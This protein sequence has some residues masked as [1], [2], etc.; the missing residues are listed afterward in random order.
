MT[1]RIVVASLSL[2]IISCKPKEEKLFSVRKGPELGISFKNAIETSDTLNALSFEYIYNGS[3][4]GVGDF[5]KDGLEDLVFGGNQVS[6]RLYL[7]KGNLQFVDVTDSA[8]LV[9][10]QWITGVSI[11]DINQDGLDD[12][13]FCVAGKT[14][15]ENRKNLL[16][17]NKGINN[18]LPHFEEVASQYGLD[19]DSYS[20]MAAFFDYDKDGDLDMY[21]VNNWMEKFNRNNIR[22]IRVNGGAESTDNIYRNNGD[23]TYSDVSREAGVLIEGYGLGIVINDIN[24]D[25][26]PDIYVSNDFLSSDLLWINQ[27]DGTFKNEINRY[28]K[29]TTHNG[30]GMD[31]ADFN[32]D[33]LDDIVVVDM[34]PPGHKRQKLMTA[35]QNFDH[36]NLAV[37]HGYQ[38]QYMRNTLQLNRGKTSSG[39]ILFSEIG[40]M[41]GIAQTDWS[42]APLFADVDNDGLKDLFIGNGYRKDVTD[43]D[44]IFFGGNEG[45][46]FGTTET[47]KATFNKE[48]DELPPVKISNYLFK[49]NGSLQ[50]EDKTKEWGFEM[51]TF[52]NG[53]AYADLDNDGDLDFVTN[54]IDQEVII[55]QNLLQ[56][57][58]SKKNFISIKS[59]DDQ[60]TFNEKIKVFH[61]GQVQTVE[62]TPYRGF[63][64]T[65]T[66][67]VHFG[68][69]VSSSV[70]SVEVW[71]PD[72][73]VS[74]YRNVPANTQLSFSRNDAVLKNISSKKSGGI[75]FLKQPGFYK[76]KETSP[77]DI[78]TTRTLL[79]ELSHYGPCI[80]AGDVNNDALDDLF[81][82]GEA[83]VKSKLFIQQSDGLFKEQYFPS[84]SLREDGDAHFFDWDDDGDLDLYVGGASSSG[85]MLSSPHVLYQND[86]LGRFKPLSSALPALTTS[87]SCVVSA[88]YDDDGDLDLFVGGRFEAGEYPLPARSYILRNDGVKFS[89]ATKNIN[90]LLE[91]PGIVTSAIWAD[92]DQDNQT[93][94]VVAGEWM[95]V[96]VFKNAGNNFKEVTKEFGLD[97]T[98][99]W[100]N[101]VE[102]ADL[103]KDGYPE[104]IA[105][106][107]GINS[108]FKPTLQHPVKITAK[109][110]DNNGSI[111]PIITYYNPFEKKR[112]M[113][114][115]RLVLI[116]QIPA[117]KKRFETFTQYATTPFEEAF[118]QTELEGAYEGS[119]YTLASC[120]FVNREGTK[121]ESQQLP[122]V[123][124]LS[125]VND[126]LIEDLNSD[127][128]DDLILIGNNYS[129]ETLFGMYDASIGCILLGDGN[130]HWRSLSSSETGFVSNKDAKMIKLLQSGSGRKVIIS[131]NNDE[132][133]VF[134]LK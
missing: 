118:T 61:D 46:P 21:L 54:N 128:F 38:P 105:G 59:G 8:G 45:S 130:L 11:V 64:S 52:S 71:W 1:I 123:V 113:V 13:Y 18:G 93:D 9:T 51:D 70:D 48:M 129:Q 2:L 78:K 30:M 116:D 108:Y 77:S 10:H 37:Q 42:W 101:C 24:Q 125:T 43:L 40:F 31:I 102:V 50:F 92:V 69:S 47:R 98:N 107:T 114:H 100:W 3:G 20:T 97:H 44:F 62:R 79:H 109:D 106:N 49:N 36:F 112:F 80:A 75:S 115:N 32:N 81:V 76:H 99:G 34:L 72:S 33:L 95:E 88:D 12:I 96:R 117:I 27:K 90:P 85:V 65:V 16:F 25:S 124:Q 132:F 122:E 53:A 29:H 67:K 119:L 28:L 126:L 57:R 94:L 6:S 66:N 5:N 84:D 121:F 111:D 7:N 127:G 15:P 58:N 73:T 86:G 55:F 19:D 83:R 41:S 22:P 133:D 17:I 39:E 82:G 56:S 23:G 120:I 104:I 74:T 68:L 26:W 134:D 14:S 110:F 89:D 4:I 63:Q 91:R 35:G 87:A 60:D 131:N 103:N